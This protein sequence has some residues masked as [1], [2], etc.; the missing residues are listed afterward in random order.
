MIDPLKR[1]KAE[2]ATISHRLTPE[3]RLLVSVLKRAINDYVGHYHTDMRCESEL[4]V[5]A[6]EWIKEDIEEHKA[7]FTFGWICEALDLDAKTIVRNIDILD[8]EL[9]TINDKGK[10]L[11]S[12]EKF[13]I[14]F[15]ESLCDEP[16]EVI[17]KVRK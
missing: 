14:R 3:K 9:Q 13:E 6:Q 11:T 10:R 1:F 15:L 5:D 2:A 16:T 8:Q 7:P 4:M 17:I 12:I